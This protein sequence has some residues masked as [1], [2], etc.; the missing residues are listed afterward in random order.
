MA[1]IVDL[2]IVGG[3][4]SGVIAALSARQ[5]GLT[6]SSIMILEKESQ[7]LRKVLA[8][9]NGRCN[10][11]NTQ[12]IDGHFHGKDPTF[13]QA[14]IRNMTAESLIDYFGKLGLIT[15][16]EGEGRV[17]PRSMQSRSVSMILVRALEE[18][19]IV[20]KCSTTV[21]RLEKT[22]DLFKLSLQ[23]GSILSARAVIMATGSCASPD[24]GGTAIGYDLLVSLGHAVSEPRPAL[25]PLN[26]SPHPLMKYAEGVRFRGCVCFESRATGLSQSC[27]EFLITSYGLSGIAAM[28]LG[29]TVALSCANTNVAKHEK[30]GTLV[31]D[32]L[33]ELEVETIADILGRQDALK[34][35]PRSAL[36]GLVPDKVGQ[37]IISL[38]AD[39][40]RSRLSGDHMPLCLA[41]MLKGLVCDVTGTRGF[42]FSHIASG[43]IVTD[44]FDSASLMS[45]R[46]PG[47]FAC[48]ELLDV[49]GDTGGFNLLWAFSSGYLAGQSVARYLYESSD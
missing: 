14:V 31:I 24:L 15:L 5:G 1:E 43:G 10:L 9:G 33:P 39:K 48:G 3:G 2:I 26:L 29:R 44:G 4:A 25:V 8:S 21:N 45:K 22:G 32:F 23:D 11:L 28:E 6:S 47:L 19:N 37:A 27:G 17:Y 36:A 35:E 18:H 16:Q 42:A 7:P 41:Q 34:H 49:D 46:V 38:V 30:V 20:L 40:P 12:T 13:S